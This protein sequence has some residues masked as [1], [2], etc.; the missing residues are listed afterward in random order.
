MHPASGTTR[1]NYYHA[2]NLTAGIVAYNRTLSRMSK[3]IM[4]FHY[5]NLTSF[6]NENEYEK[7]IDSAFFNH[8]LR[9]IE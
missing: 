7:N 5:R 9:T 8:L 1:F 4:L 2:G 6:I 3:R